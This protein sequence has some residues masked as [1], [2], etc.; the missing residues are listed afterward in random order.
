MYK[1]QNF[2]YDADYLLHE[3]HHLMHVIITNP[4]K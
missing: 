1:A 2:M 3:V 4:L